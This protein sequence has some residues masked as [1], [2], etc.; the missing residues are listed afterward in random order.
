VDNDIAG[1]RISSNP[2][3]LQAILGTVKIGRG[4]LPDSG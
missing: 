2:Q 1:N 3:K 4:S